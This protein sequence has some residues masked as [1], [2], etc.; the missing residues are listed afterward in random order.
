MNN[1]LT[2]QL[3]DFTSLH[4]SVAYIAKFFA[5]YGIWFLY[6]LIFIGIC[7][8]KYQKMSYQALV[9][10]IA[11][12]LLKELF[13]H[14]FEVPRPYIVFSFRSLIDIASFEDYRSFPS[15]HA[16]SSFAIVTVY[17]QNLKR[18]ALPLFTLASCIAI[19]RV[20]VGVHFLSDVLSGAVFGILL[21]YMVVCCVRIY[22]GFGF[23]KTYI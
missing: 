21:G 1:W 20:L 5:V 7:I 23:S 3:F 2:L 8:P 12:L 16:L 10:F 11:A 4:E 6:A 22:E 9:A 15:A 17:W 19:S 14:L 18:F 13:V